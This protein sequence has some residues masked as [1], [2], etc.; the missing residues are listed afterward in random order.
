M[1]IKIKCNINNSN[2]MNTIM[3][4]IMIIN[5]CL[6]NNNNNKML[7]INNKMNVLLLII[8]LF[9]KNKNNNFQII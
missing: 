7:I 8:F 3:K 4:C 9:M 2:K 6:N 1:M 5:L